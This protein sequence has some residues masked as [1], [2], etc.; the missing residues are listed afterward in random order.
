MKV[1]TVQMNIKFADIQH[2]VSRAKELIENSNARLIVLP[3]LFN[4]GYMFDSPEEI[5]S[6]SED[7]NGYTIKVLESI[8]KSKEC[9]ITG[10][11]AEKDNNNIY[12]SS[13]LIGPTGLCGI[14][15]KIHLFR[16]EKRVFKPG[17]LPLRLY[18]IDGFNIG[19]MICFDWLFPEI[20][21]SYALMG[22]DII[23]HSANLV[24]PFC[25]DA[26]ITRALENRMFFILS[27]RIGCESMGDKLLKFIG[28]SEIVAPNGDVLIRAGADV[29]GI[30]EV[31]ID[32]LQ[33]RDK[34]ITPLNNIFEDRRC[35]MYSEKLL[36]PK[37]KE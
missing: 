4:T 9:Y 32:P 8:A 1:A 13:F 22:A 34:N 30:F 31:E 23:C 14:Y 3:E 11:F 27:N 36:K 21:R 19:L 28:K 2:N 29:E 37:T 26:L 7:T 24:L 33:A 18:E 35:D 16:D 10:G 15:R 12:N 5:L 6:F 25:P 17:D 20:S